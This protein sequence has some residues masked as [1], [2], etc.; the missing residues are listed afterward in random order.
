MK[1]SV[2]ILK[3]LAKTY[4]DAECALH[5]RDSFELLVAVV[6]SA[7]CMDASVNR[8]LPKLFERYP[9]AE[10][11]GKARPEDVEE[12]IR[13][14]GLYRGKA[15]NIVA[16]SKAIS[17]SGV[18]KTM[19]ELIA[20]P[21][22]GRKTANVVLSE[23]FGINEGVAVDTHCRRVAIRLGL[24]KESD[25]KKIERDLMKMYPQKDW[26]RVTDLFIAHGRRICKAPRPLCSACPVEKDCPKIGVRMKNDAIS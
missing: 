2:K 5:Y 14:I 10:S 12:L 17:E 23:A 20:L 7:Q 18:P 21:G 26:G 11:L 3:K 16:L 6:L 22:V 8:V 19:E 24:T 4:P 9:D 25:P 15:R 1:R 13:T